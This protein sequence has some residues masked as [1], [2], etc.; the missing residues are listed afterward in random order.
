MDIQHSPLLRIN[1]AIE[2]ILTDTAT[3]LL[4]LYTIFNHFSYRT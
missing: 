4:R 1:T 3:D 2:Y